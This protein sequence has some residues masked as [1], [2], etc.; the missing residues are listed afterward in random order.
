MSF[1][2][3]EKTRQC[4]KGNLTLTRPFSTYIFDKSSILR[5]PFPPSFLK[6]VTTTL[7][8][9]CKR[10]F[11]WFYKVLLDDIAVVILSHYKPQK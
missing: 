6:Q 9:T 11:W 5:H 10:H 2:A 8:L 7:I 1:T 4:K 3:L